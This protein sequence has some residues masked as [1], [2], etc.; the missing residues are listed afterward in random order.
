ML[1]AAVDGDVEHDVA[2]GRVVS[3]VRSS[4]SPTT[5]ATGFDA[6]VEDA[7]DQALLAQAPGF[8]GTEH[9]RSDTSSL[10]RSPATA[11]IVAEPSAGPDAE[12]RERAVFAARNRLELRSYGRCSF[13]T[14]WSVALCVAL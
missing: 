8:G 10:T 7:R 11:A 3:A 4:R 5:I 13:F 2:A 14:C 12:Y 9:V 6:A 1:A